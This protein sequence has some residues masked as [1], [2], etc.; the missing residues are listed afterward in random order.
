M[1]KEE[2]TAFQE[3]DSEEKINEIL[4]SSSSKKIIVAGPGTGKTY[5]FK[6]ILERSNSKQ[7]LVISFINRLINDLEYKLKDYA[8]VVTFHKFCIH[9]FY[10]QFPGWKIITCLN[11]IISSDLNIDKNAFDELFH[12]MKDSDKN[13]NAFM[14]RSSYYKAAGF[15]DSIYRVLQKVLDN[16]EIISNFENILI[17]EFQDF[18]ELEVAFIHQLEKHGKVLIVGDD[19]QAIYQSKYDLGKSLRTLYNCGSYTNFSL[20]YCRRCPKVIVNAVK[21]I[22]ENAQSHN[23]L[24]DRIKK[25]YT[26][27]EPSTQELNK[28][29]PKLLVYNM[30][31]IDATATFLNH[32]I[33]LIITSDLNWNNNNNEPLI[34]IIGS[35]L[36]YNYLM[37]HLSEISKYIEPR[38][39]EE[40]EDLKISKGYEL[41]MKDNESNL[42]WRIVLNNDKLRG[43]PSNKEIIKESLNGKNLVDILPAVYKA[44]HLELLA[45]LS[46]KNMSLEE[47]DK[48]KSK[49]K[50]KLNNELSDEI[51][52]HF[53][54]INISTS[55]NSNIS[56]PV[57]FVTYQGAKG[58]AA[59]Y[60]FIVGVNDGVI[61]SN[62]SDIKD[63]EI[64]EF[65]VALTRTRKKCIIMP[66]KN[67]NGK[68]IKPSTFLSWLNEK[69]V[70][71][72]VLK[73]EHINS[74]IKSNKADFMNLLSNSS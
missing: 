23:H 58:L 71:R 42:G 39:K 52:S 50:K 17:D 40:N 9:I 2:L 46:N 41:L 28:N 51:I 7:N 69:E 62:P 74:G 49:I 26:A 33:E 56:Y 34:L 54:D 72:N 67:V 45:L 63:F 27:F 6:L 31:S 19:D 12:K 5:V 30:A 11:E 22:I 68:T 14:E 55:E 32:Y 35:K 18:S 60:V 24:K 10:S 1:N 65:I 64:C 38:S 25:E 15:N 36:Y 44:K 66:I 20:P 48:L 47:N 61:P 57:Q 43:H 13:F 3:R 37:K 16:P 73:K 29:Y 4:N 70:E 59:D 53:I 21:D 8:K